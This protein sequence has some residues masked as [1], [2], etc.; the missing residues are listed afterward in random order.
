MASPFRWFLPYQEDWLKDPARLKIWEK[1][2]RI[3]ATYVQAYEDVIDASAQKD[4]VDVWFSSADETAAIEYI[5]YCQNWAR[6]L[7][8]GAQDLGEQIVEKTGLRARI[9]A[10]SNGK[11]IYGLSSN[12]A[13]FRSKGGKLVLDEYA[14]H[15]DPES[16]WRAAAPIITWG[17]KARVL[18]TYN[19]ASGRYW[20]MVE[21]ARKG[22]LWSLHT[23][24]IQQAVAQGLADRIGGRKLGDKARQDFIAECRQIAGDEASFA[25]E[26]LCQPSDES[27]AWLSW[28]LI[29]ACEDEQAGQPDL[30]QGQETYLGVD[31]ARRRDLTV[32]W[33]IEKI[34]DI[35]WTR[36]VI[37]MQAASFGEQD[38]CLADLFRRYH[39]CRAVMD[40]TGIGEKPVE[41]AQNRY[42]R[43]LV[44]GVVFTAAFKHALAIL[45]KR[46][47]ES[48]QLRI[49]PMAEIRNAH[50]GLRKTVTLA[51]NIRFDA[52]RSQHGHSDEFWAHMLALHGASDVPIRPAGVTIDSTK[53]SQES[54]FS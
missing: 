43:Y 9:I 37:R 29:S 45:G 28:E 3:G 7:A 27:H 8:L 34:G 46:Y 39:I 47:F 53:S 33:V 36:E 11:R 17:H 54:T 30:Y 14:F 1:S 48:R 21:E 42:G 6:L 18:S 25:E 35:F 19:G 2:R 52:P 32:F 38:D 4:G 31:I 16:M 13:G 22:N 12:P 26:Y 44:E 5:R 20:Q 41:D 49:P 15:Q 50:H 24:T 10:F 23:T 51:G 40:R